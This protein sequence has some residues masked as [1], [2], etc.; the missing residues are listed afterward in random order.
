ME[1]LDRNVRIAVTILG[2]LFGR[3][4]GGG[5]V[6]TAGSTG[7]RADPADPVLA[8]VSFARLVA[9]GHESPRDVGNKSAGNGA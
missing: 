1:S 3:W 4:S 5:S 8:R 9:H 7:N 6:D 2:G